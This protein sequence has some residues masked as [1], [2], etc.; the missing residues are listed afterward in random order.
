MCIPNMLS[1]FFSTVPTHTTV[2]HTSGVFA[3]S[4]VEANARRCTYIHNYVRIVKLLTALRPLAGRFL[5]AAR[6][7]L[8]SKEQS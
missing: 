4:Y 6:V 3:L 7:V 5:L 2:I 8:E 1:T